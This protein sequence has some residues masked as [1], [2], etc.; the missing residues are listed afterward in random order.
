M[1]GYYSQAPDSQSLPLPLKLM[2][3][4]T[5]GNFIGLVSDRGSRPLMERLEAAS[6]SA[7]VSPRSPW[8]CLSR[9]ISCRKCA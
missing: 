2:G 6:R 5:T 9:V 3:Y 1:V 4:P 8:P 7:A